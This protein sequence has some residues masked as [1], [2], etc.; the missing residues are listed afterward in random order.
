MPRVRAGDLRG[1]SRAG[2]SL[3]APSIV[4]AYAAN[5]PRIWRMSR[6]IDISDLPQ[7][8][9][10]A[11]EAIVRS[12]REREPGGE[13]SPRKLGWARGHLPELPQS[14]FDQL[15]P[16]VLDLFDGKAA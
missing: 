5:Q 12:Y 7:P 16:D 4:L 14:F 10:D 3:L 13:S 15:P 6:S 1:V 11:I 2:L 8:L 9:I